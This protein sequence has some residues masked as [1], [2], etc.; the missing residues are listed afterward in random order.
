MWPARWAS[1]I[2]SYASFALI[3]LG[4][5]NVGVSIFADQTLGPPYARYMQIVLADIKHM[6][7]RSLIATLTF[8]SCTYDSKS[9]NCESHTT[10]QVSVQ[11]APCLAVFLEARTWRR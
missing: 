5:R 9:M 7:G 8:V 1:I 11:H 6:M 10:Y 4:G 3:A 2:T